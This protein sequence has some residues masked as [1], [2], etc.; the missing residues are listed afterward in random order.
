MRAFIC[1]FRCR[2]AVV[3]NNFSGF[4]LACAFAC[5]L[6][7]DA[8]RHLGGIML[9]PLV[10]GLVDRCQNPEDSAVLTDCATGRTVTAQ[11]FWSDSQRVA[12]R[13]H[14]LG[15][16]RGDRVAVTMPAGEV[17][18]HVIYACFIIGAVPAFVDAGTSKE[19]LAKCVD[20]LSPA[21]WVSTA[22]VPGH[23]T[24][25]SDQFDVRYSTPTADE[26]VI[27]AEVHP[28]D[29]VLL[30][31]TS[32]TTGLPKGVPWTGSQLSSYLR[33]QR[34]SYA[35]FGVQSEFAF[36]S[37]LG[38]KAIAM[39]RRAVIPALQETQ[40]ALLS[41]ADAVQQM[42]TYGCDYVFASPIFWQRLTEHC[43][44]KG[45]EAPPVK[46][47][48]TAGAAVN[49]EMLAHL[50]Q[51]MPEARLYV[52]YASTEALMPVT[53]IDSETLAEFTERGTKQGRGVPLGRAVDTRVEVIASEATDLRDLTDADF[54]AA[55]Q[56]GELIVSGP[57]VT[58]EYFRRPELTDYAK[59]RHKGDDS[60]WHR[61]G[62]V[63]YVD[64]HSMVWFLCRK[65][66]VVDTAFG[67]VYPDQQEQ[68]YNHHL[69][70][71]SSAVIAAP[72]GARVLLVLPE[73]SWGC[74]SQ[75]AVT[76]VAEQFSLPVPKLVFYP[77][78]LPSD[79]RHNSKIDREELSNWA[80]VQGNL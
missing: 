56:I 28:D 48:A 80:T 36:F 13:L 53:L 32:G 40:P 25:L 79:R 75:E 51:V 67:R 5:A 15:I 14:Q 46:V 71:Y 77:G 12:Y 44:D 9:S 6:T 30:L 65:K 27:P 60:L 61:M 45:V 16:T 73:S 70:V 54:L 68:V 21:L 62:D 58:T 43:A 17:F 33:V 66:H 59:L 23:E 74:V 41:I 7:C 57:R 20:E 34:D 29:A 3:Q 76:A 4:R 11:Q 10:Q 52:P 64:E 42:A 50:A 22:P 2:S 63:G 24:Y 47:G 1:V 35:K 31:Y 78:S 8:R 38:I 55:G 18:A 37:H 39:G 49:Q 19:V 26:S 72:G 69:G